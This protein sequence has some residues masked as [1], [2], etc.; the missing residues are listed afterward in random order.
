MRRRVF[1]KRRA[2]SG[3]LSSAALAPMVDMMTILV[4]AVLRTWSTD[5]PAQLPEEG[6]RLPLSSQ[7]QPVNRG[8]M[9]DV[10]V[11]GLYVEGWR[12][13]SARYWSESDDVLIT[14]LYEAL[15]AVSGDRI[16]VRA[17]EAAP[18]SLVGKVLFTAKQAGYAHVE[19]IAVS[20]AS[21]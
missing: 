18:W 12:A 11:D 17:H 7:E 4:I 8:I 9:V 20:R 2:S 15:Q 6:L 3:G 19:L 14:D 13:G 10:G 16:T 21:L 1:N 5:A